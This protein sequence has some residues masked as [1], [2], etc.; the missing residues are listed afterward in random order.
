MLVKS[1]WDLFIKLIGVFDWNDESVCNLLFAGLFAME[2]ART[3]SKDTSICQ[4]KY[5]ELLF[6]EESY[7][8]GNFHKSQ[9]VVSCVDH[10]NAI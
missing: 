7:K 10:M 5:L 2:S 4:M 3:H 9:K 1:V 6:V 8:L